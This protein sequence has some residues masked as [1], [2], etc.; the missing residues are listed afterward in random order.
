MY[1]LLKQRAFNRFEIIIFNGR[2]VIYATLQRKLHVVTPLDL[3]MNVQILGLSIEGTI[4]IYLLPQN[5]SSN[6]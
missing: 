4:T 1:K 6:L 3:N 2:L 5:W